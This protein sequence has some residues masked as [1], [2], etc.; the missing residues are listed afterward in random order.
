MGHP[1]GLELRRINNL[2]PSQ[3]VTSPNLLYYSFDL[4]ISNCEETIRDLIK[5]M[6]DVILAPGGP[7]PVSII[8]CL[9]P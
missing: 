2:A 5:R 7:T 1:R 8:R 3:N 6:A 9:N 4:V